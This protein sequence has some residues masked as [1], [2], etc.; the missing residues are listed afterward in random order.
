MSETRHMS[1]V[2]QHFKSKAHV[3][4]ALGLARNTVTDWGDT[5]PARHRRA[6]ETMI[7][8]NSIPPR[9]ARAYTYKD[10][11]KDDSATPLLDKILGGD[12][13]R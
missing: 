8:S 3:A 2:L 12:H 9:T 13:E 6:L 11:R 5:V 4:Q 10:S 1:Y 7:E